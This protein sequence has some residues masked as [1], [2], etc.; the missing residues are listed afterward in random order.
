LLERTH[1]EGGGKTK[2]KGS[3]PGNSQK[4]WPETSKNSPW[5]GGKY[6][7]EGSQGERSRPG[8]DGPGTQ[9]VR[10]WDVQKELPERRF[11]GG[12]EQGTG[13]SGKKKAWLTKRLNRQALL[14]GNCREIVNGEKDIN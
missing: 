5:G 4:D 11:W 6:R 2:K 1:P 12:E 10:H 9:N 7:K 14:W 3:I 13:V 8:R